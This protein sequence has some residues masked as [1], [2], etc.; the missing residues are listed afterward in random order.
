MKKFVPVALAFALMFAFGCTQSEFQQSIGGLV[1]ELGPANF[2]I[3]VSEDIGNFSNGTCMAMLCQNV[4]PQFPYNI[5]YDSS[6]KGGNCSFLPCNETQYN[7]T[8]TGKY[9]GVSV[10]LFMFGAGQSFLPFADAN[11]YCNNSMKMSVKWL[12]GTNY[13]TYPM[14]KKERAE[15]F[16]DKN[17]I[18]TYILY[19]NFTNINATRAGEIAANLNGA[20][21]AII[22]SEADLDNSNASNYPLVKNEII[23]MKAKCPKCLIALG[24]KLN[25]SSEYNVTQ[26]LF[27]DSAF[28][29]SVDIVAYGVNS[30]YFS[31][32][33][34]DLLLWYAVNYSKFLLFNYTKPSLISYA[35]FDAGNSSD[36]SCRWYNETVGNGYSEL[37]A[38]VGTFAGNGIIGASLYSFYG[39]GPFQC[40]DCAFM[41]PNSATC[42]PSGYNPVQLNPRFFNYMG[43]C[44]AYYSG[45]GEN[46][47]GIMPPVFSNGSNNCNYAFNSNILRYLNVSD[48][49]IKPL[50]PY[51]ITASKPFFQCAGCTGNGTIP[52]E[53]KAVPTPSTS[54]C[55]DYKPSIEIAAD[56]FDM[57]PALL[58]AAVWQESNFNK[59][60]VSYVPKSNMN[61]NP[62][63][64][65]DIPDPDPKCPCTFAQQDLYT[66]PAS[67]NPVSP[68][69]ATGTG[70]VCKPCAFGLA[71]VIEYPWVVY[72]D[73]PLLPVPDPVRMCAMKLT[74][75]GY[76]DFD[77]FRPYDGPCAYAYKFMVINLP[78]S[79]A[80]INTGGNLVKLDAATDQNKKDW[81]ATFFAL[82]LMFGHQGK[83]GCY[84][85]TDVSQQD[86]IDDFA[87][88]KDR[89]DCASNP[90]VCMGET[91]ANP[92]CCGNKDFMKYVK[93]CEHNGSF[94]YAY[95]VIDK[96]AGLTQA[97]PLGCAANRY[98]PETAM[99]NTDIVDYLCTTK[100]MEPEC[101]A[102]AYDP[103][104]GSYNAQ[105]LC[106]PAPGAPCDKYCKGIVC[107]TP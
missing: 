87:N 90:V 17:V 99:A 57:D 74:Q 71:Q 14:A 78:K 53:F 66:D 103:V 105:Y 94:S 91:T 93:F 89:T 32:C 48:T 72:K 51:Q 83:P 22:V 2:T 96:Y 65:T 36:G 24:I 107:P 29:Q 102:D 104:S 12:I 61:C 58:R 23:T 21:P 54:Q 41:D 10:R 106:C 86:W 18:P 47:S 76:P 50:V 75:D 1:G 33:N 80:F 77:P 19:S 39:I 5:F 9:T 44:Q 98:C 30:H 73:N 63:N 67:A 49:E 11:V 37:Y 45:I 38:D 13:S 59:C 82:D 4:T 88:Q 64:L 46:I 31:E 56:N 85:L 101:C 79:Y 81:F 20:G 28:M 42:S 55:T 26:E 70:E 40:E 16:L 52:T 60:A 15:C 68:C 62:L 95:D 27:R 7:D 35:L 100:Q 3:N 97:P 43:F 6:L 34:P 69:T 25:G 8:I 92:D 84:K